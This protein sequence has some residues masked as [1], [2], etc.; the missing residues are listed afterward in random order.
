MN[1]HTWC[2]VHGV[3]TALLCVLRAQERD[4]LLE[5]AAAQGQVQAHDGWRVTV[6][7]KRFKL[8]GVKLF[9]VTELDGGWQHRT[10]CAQYCILCAQFI[11]PCAVV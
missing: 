7:G 10:P 3:P 4:K 11:C 5:L 2:V 9:N 8:K 1:R 6:T